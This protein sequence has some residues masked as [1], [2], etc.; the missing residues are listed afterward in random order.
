MMFFFGRDHQYLVDAG[1]V[2]FLSFRSFQEHG[3]NSR[4]P[5]LGLSHKLL[6]PGREDPP[7]QRLISTDRFARPRV[8]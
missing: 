4:C 5:L 1:H 8:G 6:P 3:R 7:F 2:C